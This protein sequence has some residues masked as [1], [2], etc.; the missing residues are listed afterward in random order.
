MEV[1]CGAMAYLCAGDKENVCGLNKK[2]C[3]LIKYLEKKF[4]IRHPQL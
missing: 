1:V 3:F 2:K 4:Y